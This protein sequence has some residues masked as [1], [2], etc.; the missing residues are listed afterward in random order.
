MT[1]KVNYFR[2]SLLQKQLESVKAARDLGVIVDTNFTFNEHIVSTVSSC[3]SWLGQVNPVKHV[4]EKNALIIIT[5]ALV[6]L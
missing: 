4:F 6:F 5:N 3:M 1:T 2:L